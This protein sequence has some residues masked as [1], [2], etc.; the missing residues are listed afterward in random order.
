[1]ELPDV[2][3]VL[4]AEPVVCKTPQIRHG[5]KR[6]RSIEL[7]TDLP[8]MQPGPM[9]TPMPTDRVLPVADARDLP[10]SLPDCL[11]GLVNHGLDFDSGAQQAPHLAPTVTVKFG[12]DFSG[13]EV[14]WEA[15][16]QVALESGR[17]I[18]LQH[19]FSSDSNAYCRRTLA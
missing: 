11:S 19:I 15:A 8:S 4:L 9:P 17:Q 7:P 6:R 16:A 12:G 10:E 2:L 18:I 13:M 5:Q 3:P 14:A 1:M